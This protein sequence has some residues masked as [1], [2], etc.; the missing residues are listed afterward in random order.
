[1]VSKSPH[2]LPFKLGVTCR[3]AFRQ[4]LFD[5]MGPALE[6]FLSF[7]ELNSI[8]K[9]VY[10]LEDSRHFVDKVLSVLN[11]TYELSD[12]EI[13]RIPRTGP[14]VVVANH[15]YGAIEGI[16]LAAVLRTVRPDVRIMANYLLH[17]IPELRDMMFFVDPFGGPDAVK[18][19]IR[20]IRDSIDWVREGHILGVFPAGEVSHL[21][22][23]QYTVTDPPWNLSVARIIRKTR[24]DVTPIFFNGANGPFF[25]LMGLV[26]PKLRTAMLPH[27]L[28][29]KKRATIPMRVGTQVPFAKIETFASDQDLM[30]YLR[31]RTYILKNRHDRPASGR[32]ARSSFTITARPNKHQP[33][34]AGQDAKVMA[35]EIARLPASQMLIASKDLQ[36]WYAQAAQI[37]H[38]LLEIG[39]LRELTFRGVHEG[40]GQPIDLDRFDDHYLH[41]FAWEKSKREVV[42][43]YRM[44]PTDDILSTHGV[45]GLYTSTLFKYRYT[46]LEQISPALELGRSFIRPEYQKSYP[47]LLLLWKGIGVFVVRNPRYRML[48][49]PV[50]I[51]SEYQSLSRQLIIRFLEANNFAADLSR[52]IRPKHPL[53]GKKIKPLEIRISDHVVRDMDEVSSLISEVENDQK[54]IPILLKQYLK[55][56]AKF[57][58]FNV[59]PNFGDV[60]DGLMLVDL[61]QTDP[62]IL[63]RY[64]GREEAA[65]F[66]A[67]HQRLAAAPPAVVSAA[68]H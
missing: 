25:Q 54:G 15:P 2:E 29:N 64:L 4:K 10:Q 42:G 63:E 48:F 52:L 62:K 53:K 43:A 67:Y 57:M 24:A 21:R 47:P 18:H 61:T 32:S 22:L 5:L 59:D 65:S 11:I 16:V 56:G 66:L 68:P 55:V 13:A 39:R 17:R 50:S 45:D 49:G 40:T 9:T 27:E 26:H 7:P 20:A 3:G 8:Y 51:N 37:P 6:R 38:L 1:M 28:L 36:I 23:N 12:E 35:D 31:L 33:I 46:L 58:G 14:L 44:G 41:L 34:V 60:L 30:A 19:N